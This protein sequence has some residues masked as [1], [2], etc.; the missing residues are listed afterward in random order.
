MPS[1]V[2]PEI[3]SSFGREFALRACERLFATMDEQVKFQVAGIFACVAA[4]VAF[5][6]VGSI[7]YRLL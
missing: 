5:V 3:A 7:I 2:P 4:L 1:H 6:G